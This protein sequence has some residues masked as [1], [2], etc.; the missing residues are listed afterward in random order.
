MDFN[1]TTVLNFSAILIMFYCLYLVLSLKSSIPG[2][3][4]GKRWNFL[5]M[6]VVL[7]TIG[8]LSTPF[9]DQLPDDIL[10]LVVSG[11]FLFGA[12]YVVVTVRLIF[13][14]IRE[15]TE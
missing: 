6:L 11:I 7:F 10:R 1:I 15:L 5:S 3:M 13:N 4:V 14:I 12:V 9:F 2:G 8:Y